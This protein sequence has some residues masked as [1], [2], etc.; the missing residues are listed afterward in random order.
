MMDASAQLRRAR[1]AREQARRARAQARSTAEVAW[2]QRCAALALIMRARELS[3]PLR[4]TIP[5]TSSALKRVGKLVRDSARGRGTD[6]EAVVHATHEVL[7]HALDGNEPTTEP[8]HIELRKRGASLE[9]R[10]QARIPAPASSW[11][12]Y[13]RSPLRLIARLTDHLDVRYLDRDH[14]EIR[15]SFATT[16]P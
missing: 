11:H 7:A 6:V 14:V 13:A 16:E 12:A 4:L 9:L 10:V 5:P 1:E 3:P 15:A 2:R 8:I